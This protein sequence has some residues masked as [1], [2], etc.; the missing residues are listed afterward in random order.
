MNQFLDSGQIEHYKNRRISYNNQ[1]LYFEKAAYFKEFSNITEKSLSKIKVLHI[2][3]TKQVLFAKHVYLVKRAV[4]IYFNT[5]TFSDLLD[6]YQEGLL[7][8]W[9]MID[10]FSNNDNCE[11]FLGKRIRNRLKVARRRQLNNARV[12]P[13]LINQGVQLVEMPYDIPTEIDNIQIPVREA[14]DDLSAKQRSVMLQFYGVGERPLR[15][16]EIAAKQGKTPRTIRKLRKCGEDN[17]AK[18]QKMQALRSLVF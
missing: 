18:N 11:D 17:L 2:T 6:L 9:S 16:T 4:Y 3:S 7:Y 13:K 10:L 15:V 1:S 5:A 12:L 14:I 8:L